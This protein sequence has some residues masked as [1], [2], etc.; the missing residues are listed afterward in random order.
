M[1]RHWNKDEEEKIQEGSKRETKKVFLSFSDAQQTPNTKKNLYI[2]PLFCWVAPSNWYFCFVIILTPIILIFV[3]WYALLSA[4]LLWF[5]CVNWAFLFYSKPL[6]AMEC[7]FESCPTRIFALYYG[8][9]WEI[10]SRKL[11][12]QLSL[13]LI[14]LL[15]QQAKVFTLGSTE[16]LL[17]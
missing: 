1:Y 14:L 5:R 13:G 2:F 10:I 8:K 16:M 4:F 6:S 12:S 17:A 11:L 9:R 3:V 7:D 15:N